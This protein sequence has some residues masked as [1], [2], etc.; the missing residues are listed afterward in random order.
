[1]YEGETSE[2]LG[3]NALIVA[4]C[5]SFLGLEGKKFPEKSRVT[6]VEGGRV[7]IR[8]SG[9]FCNVTSAIELVGDYA[10]NTIRYRRRGGEIASDFWH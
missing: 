4:E 5:D 9:A 1:M 8:N 2:R 6:R 7:A 10:A 3:L